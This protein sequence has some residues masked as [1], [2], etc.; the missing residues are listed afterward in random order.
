MQSLGWNK[1]F[2]SVLIQPRCSESFSMTVWYWSLWSGWRVD[3]V[4]KQSGIRGREHMYNTSSSYLIH[5]FHVMMPFSQMFWRL[6]L[7]KSEDIPASEVCIQIEFRPTASRM[8]YRL[9]LPRNHWQLMRSLPQASLVSLSGT[10]S[11][12]CSRNDCWELNSTS[13]YWL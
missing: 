13:Y 8:H 5:A 12:N 10:I 9:L 1:G 4:E 11:T 6:G 3:W 7:A 2:W